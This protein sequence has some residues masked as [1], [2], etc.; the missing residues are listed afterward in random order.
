MPLNKS[1]C[2]I[3]ASLAALFLTACETARVGWGDGDD[4]SFSGYPQFADQR[5]QIRHEIRDGLKHHWLDP[6]QA[7]DFYRALRLEQQRED[8]EFREHGWS[9]PA[10]DQAEIRASLD[11]I[12]QAV[13]EARGQG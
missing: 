1:L 5:S 13:G 11:V 10:W 12:D 7:N 3:A 4:H 6:E 9:L 2:V 8:L